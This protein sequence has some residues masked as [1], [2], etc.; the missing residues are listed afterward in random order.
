[1]SRKENKIANGSEESP[2]GF[3]DHYNRII[4]NDV[5]SKVGYPFRTMVNWYRK[6]WTEVFV[7]FFTLIV[8]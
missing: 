4:A 5:D 8:I 3:D 2:I 7:V 6:N 1:M